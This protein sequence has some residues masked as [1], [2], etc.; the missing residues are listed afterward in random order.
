MKKQPNSIFI[1]TSFVIALINERDLD[2]AKA[3]KLADR[4]NRYPFVT[5][6]SILQEIENALSPK[7]KKESQ[8]IITHF[9]SSDN[10]TIIHLS[11]LLLQKGIEMYSIYQGQN[12]DLVDCL[13]FVVMHEMGITKALTS[14]LHFEQANFQALMR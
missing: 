13:A 12:W 2:H 10:V 3:L 9:H 6:D 1:D 4:Y 8:E 7:Y 5:I 11:S 14:D